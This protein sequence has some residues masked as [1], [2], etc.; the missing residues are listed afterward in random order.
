[1]TFA[2]SVY[3]ID[4]SG[5]NVEASGLIWEEGDAD[6]PS[7]VDCPGA[8]AGAGLG[9]HDDRPFC[10]AQGLP[11][12]SVVPEYAPGQLE[13]D[14]GHVDALTAR[15]SGNPWSAA[16]SGAAARAGGLVA[17]FIAARGTA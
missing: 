10:A 8:R 17:T 9:D 2:S 12:K 1:V 16:P 11:A 15:F 5:N 14:L 3:G 13:V 6:P 7:L 4:A